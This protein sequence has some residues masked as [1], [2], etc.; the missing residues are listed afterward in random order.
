MKLLIWYWGKKGGGAKYSEEIANEF[1]KIDYDNTFLSFSKQSEVFENIEKLTKNAFHIN[2]YHTKYGFVLKTLFLPILI[3]R[4][5]YFLKKYKIDVVLTTMP[6]IW[7]I[8][9]IPFFKIFGIRHIVTIHDASSHPGDMKIW[10]LFNSFLVKYSDKTIVLSKHVENELYRLYNVKKTK[11]I[12][13]IHGLL[14]YQNL[15]ATPKDFTKDDK[16]R[17]VFFGRIEE[18]KG[19]KHLLEA[20]I[21][22]EKDYD[23]IILEIYGSGDLSKYNYLLKQ[24]KNIKVENRW[25]KDDEIYSIFADACINIAPYI[26]ASQSGTIPVALSCG[27][28]TI[29]TNAGALSEQIIHK[30]T[31]IVIDSYDITDNLLK[32]IKKLESE[33]EILNL[34]SKSAL[35]YT[36]EYLSWKVICEK[37]K[38]D[39]IYA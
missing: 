5:I 14:G 28:P 27:I 18:Y 9:F 10:N 4:F 13:S 38:K 31:G 21:K 16:L 33:R 36:K 22:I 12:N 2:T 32:Q 39:I 26:E 8:F 3:F 15:D 1:V 19:L 35:I 6:H 37:L 7:T 34:M 25:I 30:E 24:I 29:C 23:N 17:L 20:Q 11:I